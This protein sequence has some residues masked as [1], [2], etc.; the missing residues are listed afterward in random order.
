MVLREGTVA[1]Q[2]A[3]GVSGEQ[4]EDQGDREAAETGIRKASE[5]TADDGGRAEAVY[6]A[7]VSPPGTAKGKFLRARARAIGDDKRPA[8]I[9]HA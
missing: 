3:E 5:G 2:E 1:G 4:R 6:A 7:R 8:F 9:R